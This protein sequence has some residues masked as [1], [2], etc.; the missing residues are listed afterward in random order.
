[1]IVIERNHPSPNPDYDSDPDLNQIGYQQLG[2]LEDWR[3]TR[4]CQEASCGGL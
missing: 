3:A 4:V 1:M 2:T